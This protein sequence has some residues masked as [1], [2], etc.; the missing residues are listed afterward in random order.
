[1]K[2]HIILNKPEGLLL[3]RIICFLIYILFLISQ[4]GYCLT[5]TLPPL[6]TI[7]PY[8]HHYALPSPGMG[9]CLTL[10]YKPLCLTLTRYG[11]LPY[12]HQVWEIA[13]PSPIPSYPM[14]YK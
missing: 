12:P 7:M 13:L 3:L 14:T 1:M 4:R 10:T 5:L 9:N 6:S 11:K 8:P 2:K